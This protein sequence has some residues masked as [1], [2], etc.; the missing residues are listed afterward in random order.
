MYGSIIPGDQRGISKALLQEIMSDLRA[1]NKKLADVEE[2]SE[3]SKSG[4]DIDDII[5][6]RAMKECAVRL[7][8]IDEHQE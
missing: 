3:K 4:E 5:Y 2:E 1:A 6:I 7:Q 8:E